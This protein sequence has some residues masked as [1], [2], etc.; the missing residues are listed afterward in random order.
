MEKDRADIPSLSWRSWLNAPCRICEYNGKNYWQAGSHEPWCPWY[1]VGGLMDRSKLI[2]GLVVRSIKARFNPELPETDNTPEWYNDYAE[3]RPVEQVT[4][5]GKGQL[6]IY[7]L[8]VRA[9]WLLFFL[10]QTPRHHR[11][12]VA[13]R[14]VLE[15]LDRRF[16]TEGGLVE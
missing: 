6:P 14:L 10:I 3:S 15:E 13:V 5:K 9:L 7:R 8:L 16:G 12:Q 1:R 2:G 4:G 11:Q